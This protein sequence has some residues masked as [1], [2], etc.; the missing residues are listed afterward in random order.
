MADTLP[1]RR[2]MRKNPVNGKGKK[3]R[4]VIKGTRA[5][6]PK[7]GRGAGI[8]T[9]TQTTPIT[10]G[11]GQA[12]RQTFT[13]KTPYSGKTAAGVGSKS[14]GVQTKKRVKRLKKKKILAK[15]RG[16]KGGIKA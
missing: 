10:F 13:T 12:V 9:T 6:E 4:R 1:D 5:D 16:L 2:K 3:R 14:A 11:S 7:T 15:I 8:K